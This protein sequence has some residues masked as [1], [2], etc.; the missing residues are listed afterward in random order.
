MYTQAHTCRL[1]T[2][3][4]TPLYTITHNYSP[5][6]LRR[7]I[8]RCA[9]LSR[10][11]HKLQ[12]SIEK[13]DAFSRQTEQQHTTA[14][15][16]YTARTQE[17]QG[18]VARLR[19]ELQEATR[20]RTDAEKA[21]RSATETQSR[22]AEKAEDHVGGLSDANQKYREDIARL[23]QERTQLKGD[24]EQLLVS[25][26]TLTERLQGNQRQIVELEERVSGQDSSQQALHVEV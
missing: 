26:A 16:E 7:E 24:K 1:D 6:R 17:L 2:H 14:T 18:L 10:T 3:T 13:K 4:H 22:A 12:S 21:W 15:D 19:A 23:E 25:S 5:I 9:D 11:V 8:D 20:A